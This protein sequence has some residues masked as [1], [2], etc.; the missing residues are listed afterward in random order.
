MSN[1][2]LTTI[3]IGAIQSAKSMSEDLH[4]VRFLQADPRFMKI[5][6]ELIRSR[7]RELTGAQLS[8]LSINICMAKDDMAWQD[9]HGYN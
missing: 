8:T 7:S 4:L 9:R 2:S 3:L 5:A 1:D 6:D